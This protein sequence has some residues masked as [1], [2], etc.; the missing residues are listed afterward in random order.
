MKESRKEFIRKLHLSATKPW[1][2]NIEAE[3]PE[4]FKKDESIVNGWCKVQGRELAL[5]FIQ[6]TDQTYGFSSKGNWT[7]SWYENID[8][9]EYVS[10]TD[11]EAKQALIKE[12]KRLG[13]KEGVNFHDVV[14]GEYEVVDGDN[15]TFF[16]K[17]NRLTLNHDR[18]FDNGTWATIIEDTITKEEAKIITDKIEV[19]KNELL[20]KTII[21]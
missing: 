1:K 6:G 21:D 12:A 4:L 9:T 13:F 17:V 14:D 16:P 19:L 10:A 11:E 7:E 20:N 15:Y 8:L 2:T 3:F 5:V 18:I